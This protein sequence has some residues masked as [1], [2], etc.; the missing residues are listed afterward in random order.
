M[1]KIARVIFLTMIVFIVFSQNSFSN[2]IYSS[3]S[4]DWNNTDTWQGGVTP[5]SLDTVIIKQS[6]MT[7]IGNTFF[8]VRGQNDYHS[9]FI[10]GYNGWIWMALH[11]QQK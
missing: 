9:Q 8:D 3:G 11:F 2:I 10:I 1:K 7:I 6:E 4:N 5:T